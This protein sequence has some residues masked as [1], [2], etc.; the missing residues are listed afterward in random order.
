MYVKVT[1]S[2]PRKYVKL[3][4]AFRD[5]KGKPKQRVVATLGHLET[6]EA[7]SANSLLN[8]LLRVTGNPSLEEG[9]GENKG[10]C[11]D[12]LSGTSAL[13]SP[14]NATEEQRQ[15]VL[16]GA[17]AGDCAA[18]SVPPGNSTPQTVGIWT[19]YDDPRTEG[20]I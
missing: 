1:T 8:G 5:G 20:S 11:H 16:P 15:T 10:P 3:V 14:E 6:I 19:I 13:S 9:T 2:G 18:D 4:E 7:G 17:D 12:L